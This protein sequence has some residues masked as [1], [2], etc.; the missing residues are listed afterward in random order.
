MSYSHVLLLPKVK[1]LV[2]VK[3]FPKNVWYYK[4]LPYLCSVIIKQVITIKTYNHE[5]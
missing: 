5:N 2:F 1:C 4:N 3:L